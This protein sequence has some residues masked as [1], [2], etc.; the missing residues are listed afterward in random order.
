MTEA[1][2]RLL[3]LARLAGVAPEYRDVWQKRR[4]V[5]IESLRAVL[6]AIGLDAA[7]P[8]AIEA[9][10]ARLEA[11]EWEPLLPPVATTLAGPG[12]AVPMTVAAGASGRI[13]W[14]LRLESGATASGAAELDTLAIIAEQGGR[15]RVALPIDRT[16]PIGYHRLSVALGSA[17]AETTLIVAPP[18]CHVPPALAQGRR[19]WGLT[20]QLYALRSERNWGIG[21][22]GD[23]AALAAGAARAGA[24]A[25]GINPLHALFPAEPRHISP[26]SPSSRV[27]L[28]PLYLDIAAVPDFT[29]EVAPTELAAARAGDLIDY[30]R[31]AALKRS[32][33]EACY[34][35]FA[36]DHLGSA[37]SA[38]AAAFRR[39][40][41]EGGKPL[42]SFAIFTTLHEHMLR[43]E[44]KFCWQEWPAALRDAGSADVARFAAER[45][46]RI[47]FRQYLQ[48]E[49]DRQLGEAARAGTAAGLA[50]G[51]Y[52]DLAVGV[53]ANGADAWADPGLMATGASVG[54]PPDLLN[55]KGQDWGLAPVNPMA[56]RQ[57]RFAP[58]IAALRAN[59]RHAG[60]LRIDHVM[61][62]R[63]LYWVP[64]GVSAADG[65]YVDY[66]FDALRHI[67]ALESER[68]RCAVIGEDLGTVPEGFREAMAASSVLSCRLML[69]ERVAEGGFL[70]PERYPEGASAGFS[71]HDLATI[72]G[73]WLGRDLDWRRELDLYPD[74]AAGDKDRRDRRRERKLLLDALIA[75]DVLP[76]EMAKRLLPKEDRPEFAPDLTDAIHRF[77]AES[78]AR[79]MLVQL[80]DVAAEIEQPNLP[81]T[82]EEHANWRRRLGVALDDLL[83]DSRFARLAAMLRQVR[84]AP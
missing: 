64:R 73:F 77:L 65:A 45:H 21:D 51:L 19:S 71:T 53:D 82:V 79:L 76:K 48:W 37:T 18:R 69:F 72:K 67:L 74:A 83:G 75:A 40:Q 56:L 46:A 50:I 4:R 47:E 11:A 33:L 8:G 39:F 59:M 14:Q 12:A 16:V 20:A 29:G 2:R 55:L 6:G 54:A 22:F 38:R 57:Q 3:L 80:E 58:F 10:C 15:R 32:A 5:P 41:Q 60:L 7:T 34:A 66:P 61:A 24:G 30:P 81:G 23:L 42:Q 36:R 27:F 26:Y 25:L 63:H 43:A 13:V 78:R 31:I 68:Q 28:N 49:A 52:R 9:S 62:L 44:G 17:E 70:P 84:G 1:D 35:A